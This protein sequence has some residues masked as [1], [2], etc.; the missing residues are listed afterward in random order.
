MLDNKEIEINDDVLSR[1]W[2]KV[3]VKGDDECWEWQGS[4]VHGY[5]QIS[6][7]GSPRRA[8]RVSKTIDGGPI[9][10]GKLVCHTCDNRKCVN[11]NH[12]FL[13]THK[14]NC[15][16]MIKKG[17]EGGQFKKGHKTS[18]GRSKRE[19]VT[20]IEGRAH[21]EVKCHRCGKVSLKREDHVNRKEFTNKFCSREC[22]VLHNNAKTDAYKKS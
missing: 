20:Y 22:A 10:D 14:D 21:V 19:S 4:T 11:P 3:Y 13:G 18:G 16:D 6:I 9:P 5:G 1:F 17:R 2:S 12:L 7:G 15:Q 8:H